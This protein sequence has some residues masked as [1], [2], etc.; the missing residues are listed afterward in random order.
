M[1]AAQSRRFAERQIGAGWRA[2][3]AVAKTFQHGGP[4]DRRSQAIAVRR[5]TDL[6]AAAALAHSRGLLESLGTDFDGRAL[7]S[8]LSVIAIDGRVRA[9]A[10]A[11]EWSRLAAVGRAMVPVVQQPRDF[12]HWVTATHAADPERKGRGAYATPYDF[13]LQLAESTLS[14]FADNKETI[15]VVDPSAGCGSLLITSLVVLARTRTKAAIR[16]IAENLYG[17]ELDPASRELAC[18]LIW[19]TA[20][21]PSVRLSRIAA[22]VVHGNSLTHNWWKSTPMFDALIMN[23]PWESLRHEVKDGNEAE[24]AATLARIAEP[25]QLSDSLPPLYSLHGSGDR[26]LFKAFV[27]LAPHLVRPGGRIGALVPAAFA[28]DLGMAPLRRAYFAHLRMD[29][30]T[31]FENLAKYF[32]I[33]SRYKFGLLTATRNPAGTNSINVRSFAVEP[34]EAAGDHFE[35]TRDELHQVGGPNLIIPELNRRGEVKALAKALRS[36][37]PFFLS[38]Q[39]GKIEYRREVD[40]TQG[41]KNRRFARLESIPGLASQTDGT[42]KTRNG[43]HYV[44]VMEGRM[45]G[46]YDFFQKSWISGR[47]RTA[48]WDLCGTRALKDCR[49]QFVAEYNPIRTARLAICD[50]TSATNARTVHATWVPPDWVCGNTAPVLEFEDHSKAFV[51]LGVLNSM[52]FDW[53]ARRL[54]A[55]LHL[56]KFYLEVMVWPTLDAAAFERVEHAARTLARLN[57][58]YRAAGGPMKGADR[59]EDFVSA[60]AE[61]ET[62]VARAYGLNEALLAEIYDQD[63]RSRRGFWRYFEAEPRSAAVVA[64][65]L[66]QPASRR[67]SAANRSVA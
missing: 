52:V 39:F 20:A 41:L 37:L 7:R 50:V 56:N 17:M 49:P 55:G 53:M 5:L 65:V 4:S 54:V 34:A 9:T 43:K 32:A 48:V 60:H 61:I 66:N 12:D 51:A 27:E 19:L 36:G 24:R 13:S 29:R 63:A 18:L 6:T 2:V 15:R 16:S 1:T 67:G 38:Q 47:G 30:W 22:N 8:A 35:I 26:N 58:R 28:S 3:Y 10:S 46:Q 23:P 33:D 45:V 21:D 44:P 40:L 11:E 42:F 59:Y 25:K 31:S 14:S 64:S 57:P 62:T